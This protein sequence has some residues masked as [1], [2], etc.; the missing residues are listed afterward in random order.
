[1]LLSTTPLGGSMRGRVIV[2]AIALLAA[3]VA[4]CVGNDDQ[5]P[6]S[7]DG[8]TVPDDGA[9]ASAAS[10]PTRFLTGSMGLTGLAP[11]DG[12]PER[13]PVGS[14]YADWTAGEEQP[15]WTGAPLT[16]AL[17]VQEARLTFYYT[18]DEGAVATTG[19]QDQGFPEFVVYLGTE[20]A[21]MAWASLE[22]P[23]VVT[24]EDV[25]EISGRLSL[26]EGGLVLPAGVEPVVKIAPVQ[27]QV[28]EADELVILVNGTETPSRA[29]LQGQRITLPN[30]ENETV[31]DETGLLASSAYVTGPMEGTTAANHTIDV[32]AG[33]AGLTASLERV[34]GAGV[35]DI[36][37]EVIGPDGQVVA[38]SVTPEDD[39]GIAL[40]GPNVDA[41]GSGTW[42]LRVVN[43]GNVAV[44]YQLTA[45]LL[46]PVQ[47]A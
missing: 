12:S 8:G 40:Y 9:P 19:P 15:T 33:A 36:D 27:G 38:R 20:Q 37:L 43:Y 26:P 11:S 28:D 1:M 47:T 32:P 24:S 16:N 3:S 30:H 44:Q 45:E 46:S 35:A 17:H 2:L 18:A 39:E 25:V 41:I 7:A 42:T 4:G 22:G 29:V 14:F 6:G 23:D 31:L 10:L 13:V 21:P 5:G 34:Q